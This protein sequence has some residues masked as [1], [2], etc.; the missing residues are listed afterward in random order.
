MPA[1][2]LADTDFFIKF[3]LTE[4]KHTKLMLHTCLFSVPFA[5]AMAILPQSCN[6]STPQGKGAKDELLL[7]LSASDTICDAQHM[8]DANSI[9]ERIVFTKYDSTKVEQLLSVTPAGN[10]VLFYARQFKGIPYVASTLEMCDPEKLVVNLRELDCTTLVETCMALAMTHR[11]GNTRFVDFCKNLESIRYRCGK[12]NGY[13]S[14]LHYFTWWMHDNIS[15]GI[16][17]EVKDTKHFI[18]PICVNNH[19]MSSHPEK[20]KMLRIHPE[21]VDSIRT[22]EK[23][24]NGQDG[25]YLAER[26]TGLTKRD[27]S[28][29]ENGD[30]IAIVTRKEGIDYSHLGIAVWQNDGHLHLLNASSIHHKVVEEPKTLKTYLSEHP[31]SIGIRVFRLIRTE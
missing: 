22:L 19:Y 20:Y 17:Q 12:M 1:Q 5:L 10:D 4:P 23:A 16:I 31:S 7:P 3:A 11:Q 14:R 18:A 28:C 26:F 13:L 8:D 29:I 9:C 30:V 6:G 27:L 21:W 2:L 24:S 25:C 15:K